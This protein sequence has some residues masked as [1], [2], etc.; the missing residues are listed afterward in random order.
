MLKTALES[1]LGNLKTESDKR[2]KGLLE[3]IKDLERQLGGKVNEVERQLANNPQTNVNGTPVTFASLFKTN[4]K[5]NTATKNAL[6]NMAAKEQDNRRQRENNVIIIGLKESE[7]GDSDDVK[8]Y[9]DA[10]GLDTACIRHVKRLKNPNKSKTQDMVTVVLN[11][12]EERNDLL[13][14]VK[15]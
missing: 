7:N 13:R 14:Q 10:A 12:P 4:S 5:E 11:S 1:V 9:F 8:N 15:K 3:K 6:L 2:E